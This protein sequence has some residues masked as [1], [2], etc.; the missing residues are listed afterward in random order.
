[1]GFAGRWVGNTRGFYRVSRKSLRGD[2]GDR[3]AGFGLCGF[4]GEGLGPKKP[5][6][7]RTMIVQKDERTSL[8]IHVDT[9]QNSRMAEEE[10]SALEEVCAI[11]LQ[12][13]QPVNFPSV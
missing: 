1:M 6:M 11:T 3:R 2:R 12:K 9:P 4:K 10:E 5:V 13:L 7:S 8:L